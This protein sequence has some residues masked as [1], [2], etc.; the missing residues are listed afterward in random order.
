MRNTKRRE[1]KQS[2]KFLSLFFVKEDEKV[3]QMRGKPTQ[4]KYNND[5]DE[6]FDSSPLAVFHIPAVRSCRISRN[7]STPE[8]NRNN[9]VKY[10]ND[11]QG[12]QVKG[13]K[14]ERK[15]NARRL[16]RVS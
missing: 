11:E 9:A 7:L 3:H 10:A 15:V 12:N 1:K 16:E 2:R 5:D 13:D 4:C 8:L 14:H 6:H